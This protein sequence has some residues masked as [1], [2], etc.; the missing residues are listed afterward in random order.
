MTK[1]LDDFGGEYFFRK[2][3]VRLYLGDSTAVMNGFPEES[4]DMIFADPPYG[5]S[6]DGMTCH[7]GKR[8]SVNKG[9]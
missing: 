2:N 6:N 7:A 5:L 3:Q 9:S 4:V 8:V 1:T